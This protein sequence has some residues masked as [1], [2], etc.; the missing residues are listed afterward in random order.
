[1]RGPRWRVAV[2]AKK[3]ATSTKQAPTKPKI[4]AAAPVA[5]P[6]VTPTAVKPAVEYDA[7]G[8]PIKR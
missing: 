2:A 4:K 6:P 3:P 8:I 5:A 7:N 1:V